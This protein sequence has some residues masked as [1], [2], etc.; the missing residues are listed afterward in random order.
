MEDPVKLIYKVKNN[1]RK[2]QYHIYIFL[3][4]LVEPNIQK[5]L[6]K[7]K[8]LNLFDTLITLNEKELKELESIYGELWFSHFFIH[9]HIDFTFD[10]IR[11]SKQKADEIINKLSK[12]WYDKYI[13]DY[14]ISGKTSFN[15]ASIVRRDRILKSKKNEVDERVDYRTLITQFGGNK[16]VTIDNDKKIKH[17]LGHAFKNFMKL[18]GLR[19]TAPRP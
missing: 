1:N 13:K 5:I 14:K 8:D 19:K 6:K 11:K 4:N 2:N 18:S 17:Y 9:H 7:I 16:D 10:N 12:E 15:F 3:G